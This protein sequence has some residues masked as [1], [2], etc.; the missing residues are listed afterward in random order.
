MRLLAGERVRFLGYQTDP[1]P[2]LARA[3]I[4]VLSSRSEGFPR[5]VL[6]AMRAGLPV[7]ATNVGGVP[8]AVVNGVNGLLV[9]PGDPGAL[10]ASLER[11]LDDGELRKRMGA[12]A[13]RTYQNRFGFDR[14]AEETVEVY[15]SVL[16][17]S[18]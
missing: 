7:V 13:R 15:R 17:K 18:S 9:P 10:A 3:G 8:E 14:M 1:A 4:F 16:A 5:S 11:L 6:E 2:T 12:E